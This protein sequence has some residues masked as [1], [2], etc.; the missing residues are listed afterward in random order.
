MKFSQK[1]IAFLRDE[2]WVLILDAL[3]VNAAYF[4]ALIIRFF[5]GRKGV[6]C[7]A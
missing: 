6:E 2:L 5:D 4:L 7:F 3:A 1:L